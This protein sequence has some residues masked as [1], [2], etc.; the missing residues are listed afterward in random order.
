MPTQIAVHLN[1]ANAYQSYTT[2]K[3]VLVLLAIDHYITGFQVLINSLPLAV[4]DLSLFIAYTLGVSSSLH[5]D[6]TPGQLVQFRIRKDK[7]SCKN[8]ISESLK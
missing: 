6:V 7:I 1:L 3:F 4:F 5:R 8:V 2:T